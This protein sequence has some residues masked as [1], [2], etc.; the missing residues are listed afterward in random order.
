[1][2]IIANIVPHTSIMAQSCYIYTLGHLLAIMFRNYAYAEQES[3]IPLSIA[4]SRVILTEIEGPK[5]PERIL[6]GTI[7]W[8][9]PP[10]L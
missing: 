7:I 10:Q 8:S 9:G 3:L 5:H 1:V 6:V 4:D 2:I